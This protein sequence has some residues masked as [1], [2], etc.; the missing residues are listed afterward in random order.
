MHQALVIGGQADDADR[1]GSLRWRRRCTGK[2]RSASSLTRTRIKAALDQLQAID[3][4]LTP[5]EDDFSYTLG[6]GA[7]WLKGILLAMMLLSTGL[8][9]GW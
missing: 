4:R 8:V 5:L 6:A 3:D 9:F 1:G 7:R 2:S